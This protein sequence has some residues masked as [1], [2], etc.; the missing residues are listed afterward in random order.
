M[1]KFIGL[2][3]LF[4]ELL[5]NFTIGFFVAQFSNHLTLFASGVNVKT[6]IG[7]LLFYSFL[8]FF[9]LKYGHNRNFEK[10]G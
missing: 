4:S 3:S 1:I 2:P 7:R 9:F 8:C 6:I 5:I 10:K